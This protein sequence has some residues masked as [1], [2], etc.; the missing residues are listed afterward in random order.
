MVNSIRLAQSATAKQPHIAPRPFLKWAGGKHQLIGQYLPYFP[1]DY[2]HYYEPFVGGGAIFFH[3]QPERAVLTDINHELINV[4]RCVREDVENL[5][6]RLEEHRE[7]HCAEHYY[8]VRSLGVSQSGSP[9]TSA[10]DIDRNLDRAAR[11]IYLNKTCFNGLYRE[12]SK[13]GF[14]VPI[15]SYKNPVICDPDILRADAQA[16]QSAQI[17]VRS[18]DRILEQAKNAED[19]VYFDPPY[20]PLNATSKFTSYSRY[21]FSEADQIRL[22]DV[23]VELRDRGVKIMLSNSDCPFVRELY[24]DFNIHTIYATRNINCNAEKRGKITEVLVTSY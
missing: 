20:V 17:E 10:A 23:V 6:D 9:P 8:Q 3:L 14:N 11:F 16:L 1:T 15:G 19:F 24:K 21:S 7:D 22:R 2:C 18:F 12:N 5:I 13:G 4:Y